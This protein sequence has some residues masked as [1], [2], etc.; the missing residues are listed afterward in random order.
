MR[1]GIYGILLIVI[2]IATSE[3]LDGDITFTIVAILLGVL[4]ILWDL[5]TADY[6]RKNNTYYSR[7]E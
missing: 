4:E 7:K 5:F 3:I 6:D 1:H 2:G